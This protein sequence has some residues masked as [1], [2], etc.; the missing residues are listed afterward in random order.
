[1]NL[2]I[3]QIDNKNKITAIAKVLGVDPVWATA[4]AMVESSLGTN[5]RSPTGCKGVF[6]M[7]SI[8][9][10]DLLQEMEKNDDDL[11]DIACGIAFLHLLLKR[12]KSIEEATAHF[13]DPADRGFYVD[14]VL[15]YMKIFKQ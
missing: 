3:E 10:K 15:A 8:A 1:M 2:I 9:V 13:C 11:I 5:Q 6:Q 14:K 12:H 7:S 4:I